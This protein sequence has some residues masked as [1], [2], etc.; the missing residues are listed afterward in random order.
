MELLMRRGSNEHL[1][2]SAVDR[3]RRAVWIRLGYFA[4]A[5]TFLGVSYYFL[6]Q[7]YEAF[8]LHKPLSWGRYSVR[9]YRFEDG[10]SAYFYVAS[11]HVVCGVIFVGLSIWYLLKGIFERPWL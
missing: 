3:R 5:A 10:G 6:F 1:M 8:A 7:A 2:W 11:L 9:V 4:G